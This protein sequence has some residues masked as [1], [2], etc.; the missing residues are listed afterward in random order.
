MASCRSRV[1]T[2]AVIVASLTMLPAGVTSAMSPPPYLGDI[3]GL[4]G[5]APDAMPPDAAVQLAG[6]TQSLGLFRD[7]P[8]RVRSLVPAR[9]ELGENA[10]FGPN[11]AT[12]AASVLACDEARV[13]RGQS[14][15]MLLSIIGVQVRSEPTADAD[16]FAAMWDLYN[17]STLNFL[18]SS[19]WYVITAQTNNDDVARRLRE[20][21]MAIETVPELTFET[22]YF[23][24]DKSDSGVVPSETTPYRIRTTTAFP[25]CCFYHNHDFMFF[26]DGPAGTA[27]VLEHLHGM[28]DSSCGYQL[29]G[30]VHEVH[31]VCGAKVQTQS[32]TPVAE[33]FG[34]TSRDSTMAFNHPD[35]RTW[36]YLAVR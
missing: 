26:Q 24:A 16:V 15:P 31:P 8:G 5:V 11:A 17:R 25:D 13:G 10:Y 9:Y 19:S 4:G 35:S 34:A 36:G 23:G 33:L 18:P 22:S 27:A 29:H 32:G 12:L 3:P 21:G 20:A 14:A 30:V 6:C 7:E 28:I 1:L 2:A